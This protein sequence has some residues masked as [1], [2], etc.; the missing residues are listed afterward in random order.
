MTRVSSSIHVPTYARRRY[1]TNG[2]VGVQ[3]K[4][5]ILDT[6]TLQPAFHKVTRGNMIRKQKQKKTLRGGVALSAVES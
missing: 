1:D 6:N 5:R 2:A 3:K 4:E